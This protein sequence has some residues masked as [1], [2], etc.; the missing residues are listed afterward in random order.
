MFHC[1]PRFLFLFFSSGFA[2]LLAVIPEIV[3]EI[4]Q[5]CSDIELIIDCVRYGEAIDILYTCNTFSLHH[6][7]T[8]NV[9]QSVVLGRRW[10]S[11]RSLQ[12]EWT[13]NPHPLNSRCPQPY[14]WQ[15]WNHA[16]QAIIRAKSLRSFTLAVSAFSIDSV[17]LV[18]LLE[19]LEKLRVYGEWELCILHGK[20]DQVSSF[21][22]ALSNATV[23]CFITTAG[24]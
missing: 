14:D 22:E 5:V 12:L 20:T 15:T 11:I 19:P 21:K 23:P 1:P 10:E 17:L 8:L 2:F 4:C 16:C 3:V 6:I 13:F 24:A 9:F 18:Q 7:V